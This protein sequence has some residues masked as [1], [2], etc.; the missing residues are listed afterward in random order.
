MKNYYKYGNAAKPPLPM[1]EI[2]MLLT[3]ALTVEKAKQFLL[4]AVEQRN[5]EIHRL[6]NA[7][8]AQTEIGRVVGERQ[9]VVS[10]ICNRIDRKTLR[11]RVGQRGYVVVSQR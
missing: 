7:G 8:Y 3:A 6:A 11:A 2:E 4:D 10:R 9:N 5:F 1:H